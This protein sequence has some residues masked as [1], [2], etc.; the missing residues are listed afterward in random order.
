MVERKGLSMSF[1]HLQNKIKTKKSPVAVSLGAA[2]QALPRQENGP[3]SEPLSAA[4]LA[5]YQYDTALM[6]AL[7]PLV[8]AVILP[9]PLYAAL[10]WRGVRVLEAES[11]YAHDRG[12]F[13]IVDLCGG[14]A[15]ELG[16]L[17]AKSLLG[18]VPVENTPAPVLAA[19]CLILD[20]Y[21]GSDAVLP[22]LEVCREED[23]CF[24]VRGRGGNPS[25]G[26]LQDMV[27]GDRVLYQAV[28]DLTRRLGQ[29]DLGELGYSRAGL[30]AQPPFPSDLRSLRKRLEHVFFL[31]QGPAEDTRFAFDK[32]GRGAV[33]AVTL[34]LSQPGNVDAAL[35]C[36]QAVQADYKR[37]VTVL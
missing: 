1:D 5:L 20:P 27:T 23:K 35:A 37:H 30:V 19:D 25:A 16:L 8:P 11:A 32:Y 9:L 26:E 31:V 7:G 10:G 29:K 33:A 24:F 34:P 12:L 4:A 15:G 28:G 6:D 17:T 21:A 22:V 3:Y 13:V 2:P 18:K 36:V 14:P